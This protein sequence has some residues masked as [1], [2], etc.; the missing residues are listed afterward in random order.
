M[1]CFAVHEPGVQDADSQ[2]EVLQRA[3]Q[4][5]NGQN[6]QS[7]SPKGGSTPSG[8]EPSGP[9]QRRQRRSSMGPDLLTVNTRSGNTRRHRRSSL[10]PNSMP[11]AGS[12]QR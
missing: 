8:K 11:Y 4:G 6:N 1:H 12:E 7:I 9:A 5:A 3:L 2:R 10:G